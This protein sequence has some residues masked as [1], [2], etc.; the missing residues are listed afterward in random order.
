MNGDIAIAIVLAVGGLYSLLLG[1]YTTVKI[2]RFHWNPHAPETVVTSANLLAVSLMTVWMTGAVWVAVIGYL[3]AAGG[4]WAF[5]IPAGWL[6]VTSI[7]AVAGALAMLLA[8]ISARSLKRHLTTTG[9]LS[10][11]QTSTYERSL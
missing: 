8:H 1:L 3:F 5:T 9:T 11:F 7:C 10:T 2:R 4:I 6:V